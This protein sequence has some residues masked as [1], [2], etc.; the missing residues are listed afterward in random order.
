M[1]V[2]QTGTEVACVAEFGDYSYD[3][4]HTMDILATVRNR[5]SEQERSERAPLCITAA[6]DH[7]TSMK[8]KKLKLVKK[9]CQFMVQQLKPKD[10]VG[11]IAYSQKVTEILPIIAMTPEGVDEAIDA[12]SRISHKSMTNLS[13]GLFKAIEQQEEFGCDHREEGVIRS[14]LLFTDGC[15]TMGIT[16]TRGFIDAFS[17]L[18]DQVPQV[19]VHTLGFGNGVNY[20]LLQQIAEKGRGV[21]HHIDNMDDIPLGFAEALGGLMS[22]SAQNVQLVMTLEEGLAIDHFHSAFPWQKQE[23]RTVRTELGD[24][25]CEERKDALLSVRI[26]QLEEPVESY[27]ILSL[28]L[29]YFDVGSGELRRNSN[30]FSIARPSCVV[31]NRESNQEVLDQ[32]ERVEAVDDIQRALEVC[33]LES[34]LEAANELYSLSYLV[35]TLNAPKQ[36]ADEGNIDDAHELLTHRAQHLERM[37]EGRPSSA[38]GDLSKSVT[39]LS[40]SFRSREAALDEPPNWEELR[41][42][43][44][45]RFW[46]NKMPREQ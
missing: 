22:I 13:G 24:I 5:T 26:P 6:L 17:Q 4:C 18:R 20:D 29:K 2:N 42:R 9:A 39:G 32:R 40:I 37:Q 41:V 31:A 36:E 14:V 45:S 10:R 16:N 15:P 3:E 33:W 25:Y 30:T 38:I 28:S 34:L 8:G 27:S 35:V 19:Q 46:N 21:Y 12:I 23:D 1:A 7:S 11:V 44:C 43:S